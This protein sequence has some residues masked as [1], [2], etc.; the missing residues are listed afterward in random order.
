MHSGSKCNWLTYINHQTRK[1]EFN[2]VIM[3]KFDIKKANKLKLLCNTQIIS[4]LI[5]F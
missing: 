4:L 3:L 5:K 2:S 1:K